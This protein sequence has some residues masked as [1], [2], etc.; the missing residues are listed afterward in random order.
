MAR[1]VTG[2][3]VDPRISLAATNEFSTESPLA[4]ALTGVADIYNAYKANKEKQRLMP[5]Q[6]AALDAQKSQD[7]LLKA[8]NDEDL[9]KLNTISLGNF[10]D[11]ILPDFEKAKQTGNFGSVIKKAE[12]RNKSLLSQGRDNTH[13]Q[14]LI[15]TLSSGNIDDISAAEQSLFSLQQS[16]NALNQRELSKGEVIDK[17]QGKRLVDGKEI[18]G[19]EILRRAN[20]GTTSSE[21]IP[22]TSGFVPTTKGGLSSAEEAQAAADKKAAVLKAEADNIADVEKQ[23]GIGKSVADDIGNDI[24]LGFEASTQLDSLNR[25]SELLDI[26]G[27]GKPE[28]ALLFGKRLLG[29]E[30]ANEGELNN[31]L[32]QSFL[33]QLK[34]VFGSQF[35]KEEVK[36]L[37]DIEA[38]FGKST[39]TNKRLL[40]RMKEAVVKRSVLGYKAAKTAGRGDRASEIALGIGIP[41]EELDKI[42]NIK[43]VNRYKR[44]KEALQNENQNKNTVAP[45]NQ[46]LDLN[47][48]S[49][50]DLKNLTDEQ[51]QQLL[52]QG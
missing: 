41:E 22:A 6:N 48:L 8:K 52:N 50:N 40:E 36:L 7:E 20:D 51:L 42:S 23:K 16:K 12:A 28:Q 44:Y 10:A 25:T 47:A 30:S 26:V 9:M 1:Q 27:T 39:E 46:T 18:F 15:E 45:Q 2:A 17:R 4:T 38:D 5:Y 19:T 33:K 21:F 37:A 34:P 14:D 3:R 13:T 31:A 49:S 35:T 24:A 43:S 32:K 11:E 29:I